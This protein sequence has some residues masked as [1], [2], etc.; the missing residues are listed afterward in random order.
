MKV[1]WR[2][3]TAESGEQSVMIY[4]TTV[5]LLS[6]AIALDSGVKTIFSLLENVNDKY[7]PTP[8]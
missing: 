8:C 7:I 5:M 6:S 3:I 4:L 1:D 2:S